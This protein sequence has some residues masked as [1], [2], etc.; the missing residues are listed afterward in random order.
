[1][2]VPRREPPADGTGSAPST[3]PPCIVP[4]LVI[5]TLPPSM[6]VG[7]PCVRTHVCVQ[8]SCDR[9]QRVYHHMR[10]LALSCVTTNVCGRAHETMHVLACYLVGL[11]LSCPGSFLI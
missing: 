11:C 10:A 9:E 4:S 5:V 2:G 3:A 6:I 1:M 7:R 8:S